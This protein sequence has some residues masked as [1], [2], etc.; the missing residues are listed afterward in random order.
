MMGRVAGVLVVLCSCVC[1]RAEQTCTH[2][3]LDT[4]CLSQS[5]LFPAN[6]AA[7]PKLT[8]HVMGKVSMGER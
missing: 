7:L 2:P 8:Q 4:E 1:L 3:H 6:E 5:Y